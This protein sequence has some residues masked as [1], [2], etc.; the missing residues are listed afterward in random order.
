[1]NRMIENLLQHIQV[2]R[3]SKAQ[4][5]RERTDVIRRRI[6]AG[7]GKWEGTRLIRNIRDGK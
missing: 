1:M 7:S 6:T 2:R 5:L 3:R 4:E